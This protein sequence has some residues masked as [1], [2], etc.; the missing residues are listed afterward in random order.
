MTFLLFGCTLGETSQLT[1]PRV[2]HLTDENSKLEKKVLDL[3]SQVEELDSKLADVT[4]ERDEYLQELDGFYLTEITGDVD[5]MYWN[6]ED[7]VTALGAY[8]EV[9]KTASWKTYVYRRENKDFYWQIQGQF[10]DDPFFEL[11]RKDQDHEL[12][13]FHFRIERLA[14]HGNRS[15]SQASYDIY[16]QGILKESQID[17]DLYC[18]EQTTC[19]DIKV[20]KCIKNNQ[21]YYSW[22]EGS[23]LFI[24]RFDDREALNT[25]EKMYCRPDP[26]I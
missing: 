21:N 7:I 2:G 25:F 26:T 16:L 1:D 17:P 11:R 10:I 4:K 6:D 19:R 20:V 3:E 18:F 24:S 13:V 8:N 23:H 14:L 5:L 22:F 9:F 15:L 12:D